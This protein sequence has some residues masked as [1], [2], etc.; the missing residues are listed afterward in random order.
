[1][2]QRFYI[3]STISNQS[4][5]KSDHPYGNYITCKTIFA[6]LSAKTT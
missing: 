2:F 5:C 1:M 4:T 3:N 6:S